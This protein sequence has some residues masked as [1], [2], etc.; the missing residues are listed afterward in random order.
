M[1]NY[2]L[3]LERVLWAIS[4]AQR[5]DTIKIGCDALQTMRK[6]L[7]QNEKEMSL[8]REKEWLGEGKDGV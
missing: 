1:K 4:R 7:S 6:M 5:W 8:L 2:T 3:E